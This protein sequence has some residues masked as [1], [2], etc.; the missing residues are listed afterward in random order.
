[1]N[2]PLKHGPAYWGT[3]A[4]FAGLMKEVER[5]GPILEKNAA[6][7]DALGRLNDETFAALR[8]LRISHIFAGEDI[9]GAQLSPSQGLKLIEAITYHS[10]AAGWVRSLPLAQIKRDDFAP[11]LTAGNLH[12]AGLELL[13][14]S[15]QPSRFTG[16]ESVL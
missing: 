12:I 3:K 4:D 9:G 7:N 11:M 14:V 8:P 10:G 13:S 6:E 15:H 2:K 16:L 5:I 1:M